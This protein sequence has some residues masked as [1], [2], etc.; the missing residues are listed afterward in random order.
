MVIGGQAVLRYGEPRLAKDIDI[1]LGLDIEAH[2]I[3]KE[4]VARLSSAI[5]VEDAKTFVR[6]TLVLPVM[7]EDMRAPALTPGPQAT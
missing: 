3:I 1:T 5:P 2:P 4:V 7:D 6:K